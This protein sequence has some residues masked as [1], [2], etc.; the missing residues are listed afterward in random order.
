MCM[1]M[2]VYGIANA[3]SHLFTGFVLTAPNALHRQALKTAN[4]IVVAAIQITNN[5]TSTRRPVILK[6]FPNTRQTN[7][8]LVLHWLCCAHL[9]RLI[10]SCC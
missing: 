3:I 1:A 4:T 10:F 7:F 9:Q 5:T 2:C 8:Q 6:V